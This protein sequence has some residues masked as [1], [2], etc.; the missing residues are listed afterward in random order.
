MNYDLSKNRQTDKRTNTFF[1]GFKMNLK[2]ILYWLWF[3][4]QEFHSPKTEGKHIL[5]N[6][7][8]KN[9][10]CMVLF[11]EEGHKFKGNEIIL[12]E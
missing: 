3:D 6:T 1:I 5:L 2:P 10:T 11:L 8:L 9:F 4:N 12:N 7:I